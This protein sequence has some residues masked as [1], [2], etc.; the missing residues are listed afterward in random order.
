MVQQEGEEKYS[1][2]GGRSRYTGRGDGVDTRAHVVQLRRSKDVGVGVGLGL[3]GCWPLC[4]LCVCVCARARPR[5][6][7][8]SAST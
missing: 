1:V 4:H 2:W 7:V 6:C 5:V 8:C 3:G